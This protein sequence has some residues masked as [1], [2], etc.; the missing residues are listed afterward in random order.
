MRMIIKVFDYQRRRMSVLVKNGGDSYLIAKG[1]V[2]SI[3]KVCRSYRKNDKNF[4]L[5]SKK[6]KNIL[7]DTENYESEG[8]RVLAVAE[9]RSKALTSTKDDEKNLCI[10]GFLLFKDPVKKSVHEAIDKFEQLGVNLKV[11]S[12]D[13]LI[14]TENIAKEAGEVMLAY[15]RLGVDF[16]TK[17]KIR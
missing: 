16:K 4:I 2:E 1:A 9:R 13:S 8:Y 6:R 3:L 7:D 17:S 11:I 14:I 5:N 15:F 12:G 10:L